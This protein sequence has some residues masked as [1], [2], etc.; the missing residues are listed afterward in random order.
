MF[1]DARETYALQ[2]HVC[3]LEELDLHIGTQYYGDVLYL[4][5]KMLHSLT[6]LTI[7]LCKSWHLVFFFF[8]LMSSYMA[9]FSAE[10]HSGRFMSNIDVGGLHVLSS[11]TIFMLYHGVYCAM[12]TVSTW[13][14]AHKGHSLA[15]L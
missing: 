15:V 7:R 11:L 14:A 1:I 3:N 8:W 13:V 4:W 2:T 10:H 12:R 6:V 9:S 5:P